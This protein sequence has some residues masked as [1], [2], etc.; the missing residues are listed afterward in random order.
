MDMYRQI[1]ERVWKFLRPSHY[2]GGG[3]GGVVGW[4]DGPG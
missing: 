4:C 1:G 3:G 2:F